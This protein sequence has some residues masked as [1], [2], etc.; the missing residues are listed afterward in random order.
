MTKKFIVINSETAECQPY[1]NSRKDA[2]NWVEKNASEEDVIIMPMVDVEKNSSEIELYPNTKHSSFDFVADYKEGL[3]NS[4]FIESPNVPVKVAFGLEEK[5]MTKIG[6]IIDDLE[7]FILEE[8]KTMA[9]LTL[10]SGETIETEVEG[11]DNEIKKRF[12]V[13]QQVNVG[14]NGANRQAKIKSVQVTRNVGESYAHPRKFKIDEIKTDRYYSIRHAIAR[15]MED[16]Y[17]DWEDLPDFDILRAEIADR[18]S[19][20][21]A[22][23]EEIELTIDKMKKNEKGIVEYLSVNEVE[24]ET[25][26]YKRKRVASPKSCRHN[27]FRTKEVNAKGDKVV[28]CKDKKTGKMKAQSVLTA[29]NESHGKTLANTPKE[30]WVGK[31]ITVPY[32]NADYKIIKL[33]DEDEMAILKN[34]DSGEIAHMGYKGLKNPYGYMYYLKGTEIEESFNKKPV[35]EMDMGDMG[36]DPIGK[37]GVV[38]AKGMPVANRRKEIGKRTNR[39]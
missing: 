18:S 38:K 26:N 34:I 20:K 17:I 19:V 10:D 27:S 29:K 28:L 2:K 8:E 7:N 15:Y 35:T 24:E 13:G 11:T 21:D 5:Q 6:R 32:D 39:K 1:F 14:K 31:I 4:D 22:T 9:K 30:K 37:L 3:L 16:N 12:P 25:A 33:D 23:D 36:T